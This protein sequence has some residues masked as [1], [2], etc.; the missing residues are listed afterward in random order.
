MIGVAASRG[1]SQALRLT[2]E[3]RDLQ[4]GQALDLV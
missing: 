2:S 4:N 1:A 3:G